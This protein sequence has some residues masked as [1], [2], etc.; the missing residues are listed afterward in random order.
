MHSR[1]IMRVCWW[2]NH[3]FILDPY[4]FTWCA[5]RWLHRCAS[6]ATWTAGWGPRTT[7]VPL[8]RNLLAINKELFLRLKTIWMLWACRGFFE[9][10]KKHWFLLLC[11]LLCTQH[12]SGLEGNTGLQ[13]GLSWW[14]NRG[15]M[16]L[17]S[18]THDTTLWLWS[19]WHV[20][21]KKVRRS[22]GLLLRVDH[23]KR[24]KRVLEST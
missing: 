23:G 7:L 22:L 11:S 17:S 24:I 21:P 12:S 13:K 2:R 19:A 14:I 10:M 3:S 18:C 1:S 15:N 6:T 9:M 16:I 5:Y 8:V 20:L 4:E